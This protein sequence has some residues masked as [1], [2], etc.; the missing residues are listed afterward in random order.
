VQVLQKTSLTQIAWLALPVKPCSEQLNSHTNPFCYRHIALQGD[1]ISENPGAPNSKE[2][3]RNLHYIPNLQ[4]IRN[5]QYIPKA[6]QGLDIGLAV[7]LLLLLLPH[8]ALSLLFSTAGAASSAPALATGALCTA[9]LLGQCSCGC[10]YC[11][12][13]CYSCSCCC[14]AP[15]ILLLL[16]LLLHL[17]SCFYCCYSCSCCCAAPTILLLMLQSVP[18]GPGAAGA[19][20]GAEAISMLPVTGFEVCFVAFLP[21]SMGVHPVSG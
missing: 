2:W 8:L 21:S 11:F 4:Y 7:L 17:L 20:A 1:N 13:C 19:P 10:S 6:V 14:A 16:L 18:G 12:N 15:T 5:L 3:V 9:A